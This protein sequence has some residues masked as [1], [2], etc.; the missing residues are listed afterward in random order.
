MLSRTGEANIP[1]KAGS[2]APDAPGVPVM[3]LEVP[4]VTRDSAPDA[5]KY[6]STGSLPNSG[7]AGAPAN[8]GPCGLCDAEL[9]LSPKPYVGVEP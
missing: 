2:I 7:D 8:V 5:V 6:G 3:D 1:S 4:Y 9:M